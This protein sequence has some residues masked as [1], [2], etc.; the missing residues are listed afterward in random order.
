MARQHDGLY[1]TKKE[2]PLRMNSSHAVGILLTSAAISA[3]SG[4]YLW[5]LLTL[6]DIACYWVSRQTACL[7]VLTRLILSSD[8]LEDAKS[9][10]L[11]TPGIALEPESKS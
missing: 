4:T 11:I 5:A 3:T 6:W 1:T 9:C 2:L 7:A 8:H 10:V